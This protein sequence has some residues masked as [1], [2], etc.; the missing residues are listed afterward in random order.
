MFEQPV[1]LIRSSCLLVA[2]AKSHLLSMTWEYDVLVSMHHP[3]GVSE[4][5][6]LLVTLRKNLDTTGVS[7]MNGLLATLR[8]N[9]GTTGV[10]KANGLLATLQKNLEDPWHTARVS[11]RGGRGLE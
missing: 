4:V 10:S 3:E 9:L 8:K 6:G 5:N 11:E 2:Q 1:L 7:K